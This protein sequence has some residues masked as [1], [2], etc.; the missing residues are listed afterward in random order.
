MRAS[1]PMHIQKSAGFD[2]E[3]GLLQIATRVFTLLYRW[4]ARRYTLA[5]T[6][7]HPSILNDPHV[8]EAIQEHP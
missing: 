7:Q 8:I 1:R 2:A 3:I 6:L 5:P 4:I